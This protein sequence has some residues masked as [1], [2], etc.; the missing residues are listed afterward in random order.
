MI[1]PPTETTDSFA[2]SDAIPDAGQRTDAFDQH[3]PCMDQE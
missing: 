2:D 1:I 3:V